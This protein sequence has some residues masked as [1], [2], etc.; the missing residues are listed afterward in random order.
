MT[1]SAVYW[2]TG[3]AAWSWVL[4]Q[5]RADDGPWLPEQVAGDG[6]AAAGPERDSLYGGIAGL[7]PVLAE[8]RHSRS[9]TDQEETLAAGIASRLSAQVPSRTDTTLYDGLA[10]DATA[11][12]LLAPGREQAP[13]D[14]LAD[15]VTPQG[16]PA[17]PGFPAP[18]TDVVN[19][20]A[21]V[22]MTAVWA[23]GP[24]AAR[25]AETGGLAMLAVAEPTATGLDW[26][27]WPGMAAHMPNYSHGTAGIGAALAIAGQFLG[28]A[29]FV[30]AA[31][32]GARQ[33]LAIAWLDGGGFVVPHTLPYSH[34][35]VEPVT[36]S[37]CHGPAGTSLLFAALTRAGVRKVAG[38][39]VADLRRRC[40][41]SILAS[42][43]PHQLRP[44]FWD[45]DGRCC[46]TAGVADVL[47]DAAQDDVAGSGGR[48][49]AG[50]VTLA[51]ALVS[52]AVRDETGARW[53]FTEHRM[54]PSLLPPGTAW[55]QGAA[56]IAA[57][58]LRLARVLDH[59]LGAPVVDRPDQWW[60]VPAGL[61]T[62]ASPAAGNPGPG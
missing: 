51:D 49:L 57:V 13:L 7:A 1:G 28:R 52:R 61:C 33:L 50:A 6:A 3:E 17:P 55:M 44:G 54:K 43:V 21:G 11:L 20:T 14:R 60:A 62:T 48:W 46:G 37:W 18:L 4:R 2:E 58:L 39:E 32:A 26:T 40:L 41:R 27:M 10:G 59:G 5:L 16:W 24:Q 9:L 12:R 56:G 19:G 45:N 47:L 38:F 30:A 29:D 22:V 23:G 8:I 35:D 25:L 15:L 31:V 42:G 34:R 53:Q 36:Y